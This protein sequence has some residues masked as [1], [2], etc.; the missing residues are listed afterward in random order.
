MT[1][2]CRHIHTNGKR[3]GSPALRKQT[4]CYYHRSLHRTHNPNAA[5]DREAVVLTAK[6]DNGRDQLLW[7]VPKLEIPALEDRESIQVALSLIIG[8]L[9]RNDMD[10]KRASTLLYG[11]QIASS[12]AANLDHQPERDY[13]VTETT[14]D[15]SGT[16]LAPDEDPAYEIRQRNFNKEL[17][18]EL[19]AMEDDEDDEDEDYKD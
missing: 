2:I 7:P 14:I 6:S 16:E 4:Y 1:S 18:E 10:N 8:A 17:Q 19:D 9:A 11:L 13:L 12:N 3:C 5:Y 15:D